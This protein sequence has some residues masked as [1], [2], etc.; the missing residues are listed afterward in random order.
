MYNNHIIIIIIIVIDS[1]GFRKTSDEAFSPRPRRLVERK[2][3]R[4]TS[5]ASEH[6]ASR[7]LR[8]HIELRN[9]CV[10][11]GKEN[12][13]HKMCVALYILL[14]LVFEKEREKR[15]RAQQSEETALLF[16]VESEEAQKESKLFLWQFLC[17]CQQTV[18]KFSFSRSRPIFFSLCVVLLMYMN[19]IIISLSYRYSYTFSFILGRPLES[20]FLVFVGLGEPGCDL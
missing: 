5:K 20:F 8:R 13:F 10:S 4:K 19:V 9:C 6:I 17:Y 12:I 2:F 14:G 18:L 7:R 15:G 3:F 1:C 11:S 16:E